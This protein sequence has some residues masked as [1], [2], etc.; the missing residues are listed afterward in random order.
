LV[1]ESR[2]RYWWIGRDGEV[3]G[4]TEGP[5]DLVVVHD[6]KGFAGEPQGHIAG[7]PWGL[8]RQMGEAVP[9]IQAFDYTSE[10]GLILYVS[11]RGWPVYLGH[12]GDA[13]AKA[14]VM[15]ALVDELMARR[16]EVAY[17]DLRNE[18]RPVFKRP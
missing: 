8:A 7:V 1:W 15:W 2:G 12:E 4:E 9:A 5:G 3:L 13:S 16:T 10:E 18:R 6:I 14:A 17:I 11:D